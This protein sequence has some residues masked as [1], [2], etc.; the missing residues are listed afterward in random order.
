MK[1]DGSVV[2]KR[3]QNMKKF[4]RKASELIDRLPESIPEKTRTMLKDTIRDDVVEDIEFLKKIL[5]CGICRQIPRGH[6]VEPKRLLI[7]N[8]KDFNTPQNKIIPKARLRDLTGS[9][10]FVSVDD[11]NT[12]DPICFC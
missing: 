3:L 11:G 4:Y 2:E 12:A 7:N 8:E 6:Q 5:S 1:D 10:F 9:L